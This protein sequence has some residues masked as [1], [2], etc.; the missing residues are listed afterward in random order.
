MKNTP[1]DSYEVIFEALIEFGYSEEQAEQLICDVIEDQR[2][3]DD[4]QKRVG[5]I[6]NE[7][8]KKR[9]S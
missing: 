5:K 1:I 3:F 9:I 4:V 6:I 7:D 2:Y 8:L